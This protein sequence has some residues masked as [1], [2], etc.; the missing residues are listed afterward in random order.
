MDVEKKLELQI[1][2]FFIEN[3]GDLSLLEFLFL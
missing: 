1:F 3:N 2:A